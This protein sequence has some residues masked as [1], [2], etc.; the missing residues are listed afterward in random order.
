M[1]FLIVED[2]FTGR[3]LMQAI[4][5]EYGDCDIAVDGKEAVDAFQMSWVKNKPYDLICMDIMMPNMD[6]QEAL[7]AIRNIE[8]DLAVKPQ[9]EVKVIMTTALDEPRNV[10]DTIYKGGAA[11][12]LVKPI[13]KK[14]LLRELSKL[15]LISNV[16]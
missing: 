6:G 15:G 12:Y 4:L 9:D 13:E 1:R 3:K 14:K 11:A 7:K 5:S 8:N 2:D 16:G 10:F